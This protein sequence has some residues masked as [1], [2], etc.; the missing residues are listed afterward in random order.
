LPKQIRILLLLAISLS[1]TLAAGCENGNRSAPDEM[2]APSNETNL[3]LS[4]EVER[5]KAEIARLQMQLQQHGPDEADLMPTEQREAYRKLE[6]FR[7]MSMPDLDEVTVFNE[8]HRVKITDRGFI[9]KLQ[10]L[11]LIGDRI[12]W[13][14]AIPYTMEPFSLELK[15]NRESVLIHAVAKGAIEFPDILPGHYFRVDTDLTNLGKALLPKPAFLPEESL[16]SRML[17][18]GFLLVRHDGH[19]YYVLNE[20]RVRVLAVAFLRADKKEADKP[21]IDETA[22]LADISFFLYGQEI[23][24]SVFPEWIRVRDGE[25]ETWYV[26]EPSFAEQIEMALRA[27]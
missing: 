21:D 12:S 22:S 3:D 23:V 6:R 13:G 15:D 5:L 25:A 8:E 10:P 1:V 2:Q 26:V 20:S 24:M 4:A 9:E 14:G 17:D 7:M 19:P 27:D 11:L 16:G 18:S